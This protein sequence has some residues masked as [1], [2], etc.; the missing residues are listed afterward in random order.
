M[1]AGAVSIL[2]IISPP[3]ATPNDVEEQVERVDEGLDELRRDLERLREKREQEKQKE[4][5]PEQMTQTILV[6]GAVCAVVGSAIYGALQVIKAATS[7]EWRKNA[8]GRSTMKA[9]PLLLGAGLMA[10]PDVL[11]GLG[12]LFGGLPELAVSA[13]VVVGLAA[14]AFATTFHSIIRTRIREIAAAATAEK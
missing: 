11:G 3:P 10:I 7:S 9:A 4:K 6:L 2:L 1:I 5:G 13:R 12:D 14:G 8:A